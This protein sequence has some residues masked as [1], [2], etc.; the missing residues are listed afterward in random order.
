VISPSKTI[1]LQA[2]NYHEMQK[3][4]T[5][6][7]NAISN[8]LNAQR[9]HS[10][11]TTQMKD[12]SFDK[13]P[14]HSPTHNNHSSSPKGSSSA[15]S[16]GDELKTLW[17]IEGNNECVDCG[18]PDPNWLSINLGVLMCMVCSGH[19]RNLGVHISQVRSATLDKIDPFQLQF[20]IQIGNKSFNTVFESEKIIEE[21]GLKKPKASASPHA[22]ETWINSKYKDKAF[23]ES[24]NQVVGPLLNQL[25][26]SSLLESDHLTVLTALVL[27]AKVNAVNEEGETPLHEAVKKGDRPMMELLLKNGADVTL[28][29][30]QKLAAL[31]LAALSEDPHTVGLL[32]LRGGSQ[33]ITIKDGTGKTPLDLAKEKY[34]EESE[35]YGVLNKAQEKIDKKLR[36]N[37][38][39]G[40]VTDLKEAQNAYGTKKQPQLRQ[41]IKKYLFTGRK[42]DFGVLDTTTPTSTSPI[43]H[44]ASSDGDSSK[45]SGSS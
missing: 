18:T 35:I 10:E 14:N 17:T 16:V 15:E 26:W 1:H 37:I 29:N 44:S 34:G 2:E 40:G 6:I 43:P 38:F 20:L 28:V 45:S 12:G 25:L 24:K 11:L 36:E 13:S 4:M 39:R 22:R 30:S 33:Q 32:I 7:Q 21:L 31:H 42:N 3:W 27:G 19:H 23:C 8:T 41:R 5:V 9:R